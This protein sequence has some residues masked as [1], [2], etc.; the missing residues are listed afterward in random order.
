MA[1]SRT[2]TSI[3]P[4]SAND[5]SFRLSQTPQN[6]TVSVMSSSG[7]RCYKAACPSGYYL[8][9]PNDTYFTVGSAT[10]TVSGVV[11]YKATGC[12]NGYSST[13]TGAGGTYQGYT[14]KKVLYYY[15]RPYNTTTSGEIKESGSNFT[16]ASGKVMV[17]RR[18]SGDENGG[19]QYK[20][21]S[22][23]AYDESG[24]VVDVSIS[25]VNAKWD[26]SYKQS[27]DHQYRPGSQW[28]IVGRK[29]DGDEN[30]QTAFKIAQVKVDG[31]IASWDD[32]RGSGEIKESSG[33]WWTA[34]SGKVMVGE[35]HKGDENGRTYYYSGRI[36]LK[37]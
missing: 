36:Y 33:T 14:C 20:C 22:L 12:Q 31:K 4:S 16:C 32:Y 6:Y 30:G 29:H 9:K 17:G 19:T 15:I 28:I 8:E 5:K 21:A 35:R 24:R 26:S 7:G 18:H 10:G 3:T 37:L 23:R 2:L 27:S 34:P 25:I 13:G 1:T 11:C